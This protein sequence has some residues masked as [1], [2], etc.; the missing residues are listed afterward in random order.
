M[1]REVGL[2]SVS[3]PYLRFYQSK[4]DGSP[5][6]PLIAEAVAMSPRGQGGG[7]HLLPLLL[8]GKYYNFQID[9]KKHLEEIHF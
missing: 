4:N 8:G 7:G 5:L 2:Y 3:A 9:V 1:K 6:L